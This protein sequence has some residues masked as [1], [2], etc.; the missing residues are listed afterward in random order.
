MSSIVAGGTRPKGYTISQ[1][2]LHWIIAVLVLSQALLGE[3]IEEAWEAY[4]EG[5]TP[6][7]DELFMANIHVWAGIIIFVLALVR[8]TL[9]LTRGAPPLPADEPPA[10]RALATITHVAFY[11]IIL[12]M[13]ISGSLSWFGIVPDLAELHATAKLPILALVGL[14]AAAALWHHFVRRSDVMRRMLVPRP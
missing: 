13:P 3:G 12:I 7:A 10:L 14:H 11:A 9:R 4:S 2:A 6:A 5:A 1:I 8:V